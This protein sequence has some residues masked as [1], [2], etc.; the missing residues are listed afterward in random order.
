[1]QNK[2]YILWE[3]CIVEFQYQKSWEKNFKGFES[4]KEAIDFMAILSKDKSTRRLVGPL[5]YE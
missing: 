5:K 1:M 4:K 3:E 2:F